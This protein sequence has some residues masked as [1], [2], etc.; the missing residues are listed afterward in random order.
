M[1]RALLCERHGP[2]SDVALRDIA[3]APA[4]GPHEVTIEIDHA[5]VSYATRLLI[6]GTYQ[7]RPPLPF[8]PGTEAVGR[9]VARGSQVS[10]LA[11]GDAVVA[12]AR[13]GCYAQRLTLPE[14]TVY[15]VP[16]GLDPL[17]ALPVPISYGT[18]YTALLWRAAMQAGDTVL[19]LGA[20]SGV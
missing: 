6:E 1:M 13:W 5:S 19:V 17:A 20:G 10:R 16:D 11:V 18:A 3:D 2:V 8:V 7:S 12:V 14:H 4:P 9:I 15:A